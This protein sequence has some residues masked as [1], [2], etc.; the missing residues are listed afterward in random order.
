MIQR[1]IEWS[2]KNRFLVFCGALLL[3]TLFSTLTPILVFLLSFPLA[4]GL[5][6]ASPAT[7]TKGLGSDP[8]VYGSAAGLYGALQMAV[9]AL[10]T[11]ALRIGDS[12]ALAAGGVMTAAM[13]LGLGSNLLAMH[14]V[15][16]AGARH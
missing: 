11:L 15:R 1:L 5:G 2:L 10:G 8:K 6:V 14:H 9:A 12:P 16:K 13:L 3:I 7:L 4:L